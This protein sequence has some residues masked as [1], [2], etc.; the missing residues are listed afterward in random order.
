M[1][2]RWGIRAL[3]AGLPVSFSLLVICLGSGGGIVEDLLEFLLRLGFAF[4]FDAPAS[5]REWPVSLNFPIS[6]SRWLFDFNR[7]SA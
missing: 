2:C 5:P 7:T 4:S 6:R 3:A 1:S